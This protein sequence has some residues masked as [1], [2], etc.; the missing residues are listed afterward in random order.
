MDL[1]SDDASGIWS[2]QNL[3]NSTLPLECVSLSPTSSLNSKG[4]RNHPSL[5]STAIFPNSNS[6]TGGPLVISGKGKI[7]LPPND[8]GIGKENRF[9]YSIKHSQNNNINI[10][11]EEIATSYREECKIAY[12]YQGTKGKGSGTIKHA[13]QD[14]HLNNGGIT[15]IQTN[16]FLRNKN[17]SKPQ[18]NL[19]PASER[20][21]ISVLCTSNNNNVKD[22]EDINEKTKSSDPQRQILSKDME[23]E[24]DTPPFFDNLMSNYSEKKHS[25]A[26]SYV[27]PSPGGSWKTPSHLNMKLASHNNSNRCRIT[28]TETLKFDNS[29]NFNEKDQKILKGNISNSSQNQS[30]QLSLGNRSIGGTNHNQNKKRKVENDFVN[31]I[32]LTLDIPSN[33]KNQSSLDDK[34]KNHVRDNLQNHDDNYPSNNTYPSLSKCRMNIDFKCIESSVSG[35]RK[36]FSS[37]SQSKDVNVNVVIGKNDAARNRLDGRFN[38]PD[39][40]NSL[41]YYP[42]SNGLNS[43]SLGSLSPYTP[44]TPTPYSP[45]ESFPSFTHQQTIENNNNNNNVQ[46]RSQIGCLTLNNCSKMMMRPHPNKPTAIPPSPKTIFLQISN[47][48]N[49]FT[50][51]N[52]VVDF[53]LG[54]KF[55]V[56]P[57]PKKIKKKIP[58]ALKSLE[59][60]ILKL[61]E[62][63]CKEKTQIERKYSLEKESKK[64]TTDENQNEDLSYGSSNKA[65]G[66][67]KQN[68]GQ[69]VNQNCQEEAITTYP[70]EKGIPQLT[71]EISTNTISN[72]KYTGNNNP[73]FDPLPSCTSG[74][75]SCTSTMSFN[76][77]AFLDCDGGLETCTSTDAC[78]T[79]DYG[80]GSNNAL[81]S[82]SHY[83]QQDR[84]SDVH[85]SQFPSETIEETM[86]MNNNIQQNMTKFSKDN[87]TTNNDNT[88]FTKRTNEVSGLLADKQDQMKEEKDN[89]VLIIQERELTRI[90]QEEDFALSQL[91]KEFQ[92]KHDRLRQQYQHLW[93][94]YESLQKDVATE[95]QLSFFLQNKRLAKKANKEQTLRRPIYEEKFSDNIKK[96]NLDTSNNTDNE[97]K[98]LLQGKE[99]HH[100]K[101]FKY[102]DRYI[103][104]WDF[105]PAYTYASTSQSGS[106]IINELQMRLVALFALSKEESISLFKN[107]SSQNQIDGIEAPLKHPGN[108]EGGNSAYSTPLTASNSTVEQTDHESNS[109]TPSS[110][111]TEEITYDINSHVNSIKLN[112]T[113]SVGTSVLG[114]GNTQAKNFNSYQRILKES[115]NDQTI[116]QESNNAIHSQN[117][118]IFAERKLKMGNSEEN[119]HDIIEEHQ[120]S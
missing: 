71:V 87:T 74:L 10:N 2:L 58:K 116:L 12:D 36:E 107:Y 50:L 52:E 97:G 69:M 18:T 46:R 55:G 115:N 94:I 112:N 64:R 54:K 103:P 120:N 30:K 7:P 106:N 88:A 78:F 31:P 109:C 16:P 113:N 15:L 75:G 105:I 77:E 80:F 24:T 63:Y 72:S 8:K 44:Y 26:L 118:K 41:I 34:Y 56:L 35:T 61:K 20:R 117:E 29:D 40:Q 85:E 28:N 67:Q 3:H 19:L 38:N 99:N 17:D 84:N 21:Q 98:T 66:Q 101:L 33:E 70:E 59:S 49:I 22:V 60:R 90:D 110:N 76:T 81:D 91:A 79:D 48:T 62:K 39:K 9:D 73:S 1:L 100:K 96:H 53:V 37:N 57:R 119:L 111:K 93:G 32:K 4:N 65:N 92:T 42:S 47:E 114:L 82:M 108:G 5:S 104:G 83:F 14:A 27:A 13:Q 102:L 45:F 86:H 89:E 43:N 6:H 23:T 95:T 25:R 11:R 51:A 68:I